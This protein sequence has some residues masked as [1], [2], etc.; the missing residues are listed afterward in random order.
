MELLQSQIDEGPCVDCVTDAKLVV[1]DDLET[2]RTRWPT[3]T[4]AAL[5]AG[6]HAVIGVP[7]RL[8]GT[9]VGGLNLLY[10]VP[11]TLTW[12]PRLGQALADLGVLALAQDRA[13]RR[14]HRIVEQT[15]TG[16]NDRVLLGQAVGFVAGSLDITP[17][18][19]RAALGAYAQTHHRRLREVARVVTDGGLDPADLRPDS[20]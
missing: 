16:L 20:L 19:A 6:Y 12:Q 15:L 18:A 4:P 13:G 5:D 9:A 8:E 11:A 1:V 3:F 17:E 7:M 10:S 2:A 14:A